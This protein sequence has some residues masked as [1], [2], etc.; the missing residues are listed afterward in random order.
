MIVES[1]FLQSCQWPNQ[2]YY[3]RPK[4]RIATGFQTQFARIQTVEFVAVVAAV[5]SPWRNLFQNPSAIAV[6][7]I[8]MPV[9]QW[10]QRSRYLPTAA[11][12]AVTAMVD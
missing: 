10:F 7:K 6:V 9:S 1:G 11:G 8:L 4:G 3:V 2:S 5:Q 12:V